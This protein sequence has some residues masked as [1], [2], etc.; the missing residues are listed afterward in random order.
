MDRMREFDPMPGS[1]CFNTLSRVLFR[2][3][4]RDLYTLINETERFIVANYDIF[5]QCPAEVYRS[6]L[7][8][9]PL[10]SQLRAQFTN[11]QS[12]RLPLVLR[13][14]D[15]DW[16]RYQTLYKARDNCLF[17]A[18]AFSPDG[19]L[20]AS[21]SV[22]GFIHI[23]RARTGKCEFMF[24]GES[25]IVALTFSSNG[26]EVAALADDRSLRIYCLISGAK[27]QCTL[28][29]MPQSSAFFFIDSDRYLVILGNRHLLIYRRNPLAE[30]DYTY[31]QYPTPVGH[32]LTERSL[33]AAHP[34]TSAIA[35]GFPDVR[36]GTF[37]HGYI[38]KIVGGKL[39]SNFCLYDSSMDPPIAVSFVPSGQRVVV[40]YM[41]VV[42]IWD[43]EHLN[44]EVGNGY[45]FIG[46][47]PIS[48]SSLELAKLVA[49]RVLAD[50]S[51]HIVR[52]LDRGSQHFFSE[53][54]SGTDVFEGPRSSFTT[55]STWTTSFTYKS[56]IISITTSSPEHDLFATCSSNGAVCIWD[57]TPTRGPDSLKMAVL[58]RSH[59]E[60]TIFRTADA[61]VEIIFYIVKCG[62][63]FSG[64]VLPPDIKALESLQFCDAGEVYPIPTRYRE[65]LSSTTRIA[66]GLLHLHYNIVSDDVVIA[67]PHFM[68]LCAKPQLKDAVEKFLLQGV[69]TWTENRIQDFLKENGFVNIHRIGW[70]A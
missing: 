39:A 64:L 66:D 15:P 10:N 23:W 46:S 19:Y 47:C 37:V 58:T 16:P 57:V 55:M 53:Q 32:W 17:S 28:T 63:R 34:Q 41:S 40:L 51:L 5:D 38:V 11:S 69:G 21:G 36:A 29:C 60:Q 62:W 67:D 68:E 4:D 24:P 7:I 44:T 18:I 48:I 56:P 8:W 3:N 12:K 70:G 30:S 45:R 33:V 9:A 2:V 6:G 50:L 61:V 54:L 52:I 1:S 49:F 20:V 43:A 31:L 35:I 59:A 14:L 26:S 22:T 13:G 25:S 65:N 42:R 27:S